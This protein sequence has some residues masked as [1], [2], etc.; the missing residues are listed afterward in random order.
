[1]KRTSR[2][3]RRWTTPGAKRDFTK[4]FNNSY[5]WINFS[6][7]CY[8][9]KRTQYYRNKRWSN[10]IK[11]LCRIYLALIIHMR[12]AIGI[13]EEQVLFILDNSS[14]HWS[15]DVN[16]CLAKTKWSWMFLP[17]YCPEM[18][19]VELF[20]W[21]L[22]RHIS[23]NRKQAVINLWKDSGRQF[24][25]GSIW[26]INNIAIMKIWSHFKSK[27]KEWIGELRSIFEFK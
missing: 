3:L 16:K 24:L 2:N 18:A 14:V 12:K 13:H 25:I 9:I 11:F 17:Q 26:S 4:P 15:S 19:P 5:K 21:Q 10:K 23:L 27:L 6:G 1:M 7:N 8:R 20:F 22:K